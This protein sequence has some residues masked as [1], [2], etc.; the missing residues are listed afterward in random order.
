MDI[1][2]QYIRDEL[3]K[4]AG[5]RELSK[6]ALLSKVGLN[7]IRRVLADEG[8]TTKTAEKLQKFLSSTE[9]LKR[10]GDLEE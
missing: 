9:K 3:R 6:V 1:N 5:K 7:T 2:M 4:R 10:L 8:C